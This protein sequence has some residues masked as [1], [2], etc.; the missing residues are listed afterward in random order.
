MVSRHSKQKVIVRMMA[1]MRDC[2]ALGSNGD[3]H[4]WNNPKGS[5]VDLTSWLCQCHHW[6]L[7]SN[8]HSF[9]RTKLHNT[10]CHTEFF[11]FMMPLLIAWVVW[12]KLN[13]K[14]PWSRATIK[15]QGGKCKGYTEKGEWGR[16]EIRRPISN[17]HP[18]VKCPHMS[19]LWPSPNHHAGGGGGGLIDR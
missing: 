9:V 1:W 4:L 17:T 3:G 5:K 8:Y 10:G 19:I 16:V 12:I 18:R 6:A 7:S 15:L 2:L 13:L 11:H 14:L